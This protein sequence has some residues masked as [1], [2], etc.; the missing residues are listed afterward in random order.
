VGGTGIGVD[1]E[2]FFGV[3]GGDGVVVGLFVWIIT[4]LMVLLL[5]GEN[6]PI[7]VLNRGLRIRGEGRGVEGLRGKGTDEVEGRG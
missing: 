2:N 7:R 1:V 4:G 5:K 3:I 6:D